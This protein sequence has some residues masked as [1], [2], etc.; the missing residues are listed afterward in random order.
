V[1]FEYPTLAELRDRIRRDFNARLPGA[2]ALLRHSNL[3]VIA[4][5]FAGLV[6]RHYQYQAWLA[7]QLFP[8]TC[9]GPFLE[10]WASIWGVSRLPATAALGAVDV[11]GAA[12]ATVPAGTQ[13][14]RVDGVRYTATD[15]ATLDAA[16][17]A[18]VA[19]TALEPGVTGN[20]EAGA[21]VS[22]VT[23]IVGVVADATIAAPGCAGGADEETDE[24]LRIRLLAR[25]QTP[26]HGGSASD[27]VDWTLEVPGVTRV[28]V[29]PQEQGPGTV[30]VRFCMDDAAHAPDGIP[31]PADVALVQAHLDVVRP[32][33]A[34]VLVVAPIPHAIDVTIATLTPDTPTVRTAIVAELTD[35]LYRNGAPGVVLYVSWLWEAVSLA[36]GER[37]HRITV[38]P[39]DVAL[40]AGE[41][42]VLG[43]ITY[44][45]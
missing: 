27:Y 15:G 25:I 34:E 4:D 43:A 6:T 42:P 38:P 40:G 20:A 31:T 22:T 26:P 11:R 39:G 36:S 28:W 2:D 18:T 33:T 44:V 10:R 29:A 9:E 19:V 45:A 1:P 41:L 5:V 7:L 23:V 16:G 32:V 37:H 3:R 8:D 17:L 35:T 30:V 21:T 12:G 14:Q 24:Q 13:W